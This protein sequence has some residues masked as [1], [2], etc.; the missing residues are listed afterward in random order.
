MAR[1]AKKKRAKTDPVEKPP[2]DGIPAPFPVPD[3][4]GPSAQELAAHGS[5][6]L[7]QALLVQQTI[8]TPALP[9]RDDLMTADAFTRKELM[10]GLTMLGIGE[11]YAT[12]VRTLLGAVR[13]LEKRVFSEAFLSQLSRADL[14]EL[15]KTA[16]SESD[17]VPKYLAAV[18]S[19]VDATAIRTRLTTLDAEAPEAP[20]PQK[21]E[22]R[23]VAAIAARP[24]ATTLLSETY[25]PDEEDG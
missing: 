22:Q 23:P 10:L 3:I 14:L 11:V 19:T 1:R 21:Q 2:A 9:I 13:A 5:E 16:V 20:A 4:T 17:K 24:H 12:R 18:M 6:F 25:V 15:Y 8:D 7:T